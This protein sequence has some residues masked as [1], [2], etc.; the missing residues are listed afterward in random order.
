MGQ[1]FEEFIEVGPDGT[2]YIRGTDIAVADIIFVYNNSGGSFAAIARHFPELSE[3]QV[4]AAFLYFEENT[5]QV[6]RD[7]ANRY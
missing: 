7:L 3:E 5:A 2:A 1:A 4:D 6:Y